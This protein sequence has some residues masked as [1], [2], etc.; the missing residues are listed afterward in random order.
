MKYSSKVSF[1]L[2]GSWALAK[3]GKNCDAQRENPLQQ[4]AAMSL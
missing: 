4:G 2:E 3:R 1:E